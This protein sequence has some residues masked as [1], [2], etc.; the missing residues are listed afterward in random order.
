VPSV[1]ARPAGRLGH[2]HALQRAVGNDATAR[3]LRADPVSPRTDVRQGTAAPAIQRKV[4]EASFPGGGKVDD[5]RSGEHLLWNFEIGSATL[6][7]AHLTQ[8]PRLAAEIK[9][10]LTRDPDA[11][12]DIEGQASLT[13]TRN[14]ELSAKRANAVRDA[15]VKEGIKADR[16]NIIAVGSLKSREDR[17]QENLARSR[18]VRVITPPHLLLAQ[19]PAPGPQTGPCQVVNTVTLLDGSSVEVK[20]IGR[21]I[22]LVAGSGTGKPPGMRIDVA[23]EMKPPGCGTFSFVQNVD[24]FREFVYKDRTRNT[25]QSSGFVLDT[26]DPYKSQVFPP[27]SPNT[28]SVGANDSPSQPVDPLTEGM[29][30][31]VE[32]RDDFRMFLMFQ[33]KG[34]T[35]QVVHVAEWSWVGLARNTRPDVEEEGKLVKDAGAS[36]VTPKSGNGKPTSDTPVPSPNVTSLSWTT[37]NGGNPSTLTLANIHRRSVLDK[38]KPSADP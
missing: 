35:K 38:S 17:S 34:G 25:F 14:D 11:V 3:W 1:S 16:F 31:T 21:F 22:K 4:V 27:P 2:V 32:A 24:A 5:G 29:T 7:G 37:D 18:A 8:M 9:R 26:S 30:R 6:Q 12:I 33:P 13:G 36:R 15:L 23:S 20:T 19:G 28:V 10:A